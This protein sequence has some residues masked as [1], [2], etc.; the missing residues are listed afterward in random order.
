MLVGCI[1]KHQRVL[2]QAHTMPESLSSEQQCISRVAGI[3]QFTRFLLASPAPLRPALPGHQY[4]NMQCSLSHRRGSHVAMILRCSMRSNKVDE[5]RL[6]APSPDHT[7][8]ET[9]PF[10]AVAIMADV[11]ATMHDAGHI[12]GSAVVRM[13]IA[14]EGGPL[15]TLPL[16][17]TN[18]QR[19]CARPLQRAANGHRF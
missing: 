3:R 7:K 6:N 9:I 18:C 2:V 8:N 15:T 5:D 19:S 12:L 11:T 17:R 10:D 14:D 4:E 13:E 1:L 16:P